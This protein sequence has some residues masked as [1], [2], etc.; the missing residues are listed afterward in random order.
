MEVELVLQNFWRGRIFQNRVL[1]CIISCLGGLLR[2][3]H[4]AVLGLAG[5]GVRS[6]AI[7]IT[8]I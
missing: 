7:I 2:I 6:S 3:R 1:G 4:T 8:V 5:L